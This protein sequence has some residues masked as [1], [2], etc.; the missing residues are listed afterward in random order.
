[1]TGDIIISYSFVY[2]STFTLDDN[3]TCNSLVQSMEVK[4]QDFFHVM[5]INTDQV[6]CMLY[7]GNI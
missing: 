7:E 1:M 2:S 5:P 4:F 3:C 6:Y